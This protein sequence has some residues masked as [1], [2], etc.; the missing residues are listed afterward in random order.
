MEF[1]KEHVY[2]ALN[3]DEL[4]PGDKVITARC[5]ADLKTWVEA[6]AE[7]N[8]IELIQDETNTNRFTCK[9]F[10]SNKTYDTPL[11]YLVERKENCTNC[12]AIYTCAF[13]VREYPELEKCKNWKPKTEQKAEQKE[14]CL[15]CKS[16]NKVN[17]FRDCTL[18]NNPTGACPHYE[19]EPHYRPFKDTDELIKVWSNKCPAHNHRDRGLTMPLI[20]VREKGCEK[21]ADLIT[22]YGSKG[23]TVRGKG[24]YFDTLF[25]MFE[26][27]DG[28]PCGVEVDDV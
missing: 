26:F 3:A 19:A 24:M 9:C 27:L 8:V 5:M 21:S 18:V 22:C 14:M 1:T 23:I 25:T 10:G 7:P 15:N 28:T 11:A 4:K 13:Q 16:Y 12:G 6:D 20:W 2:T 17:D